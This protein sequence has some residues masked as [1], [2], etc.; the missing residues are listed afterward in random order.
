MKI[1]KYLIMGFALA[2]SLTSC[3]DLL[4]ETPKDFL[5]P[6]NSYTDKK[7]FEAAL[8]DIYKSI[9]NNFYA[10]SD[11]WQNYDLLSGTDIDLF[12]NQTVKG[13][14]NEYFYW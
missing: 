4:D 14:Y 5:T 11:R 7:G 10:E 3:Y 12:M 1:A 6:E 13:Q 9:R 2:G 8:A